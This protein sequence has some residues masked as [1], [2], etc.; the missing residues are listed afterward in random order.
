MK[1]IGHLEAVKN[2]IFIW[3]RSSQHYAKQKQH[4][5]IMF[6]LVVLAAVSATL[7]PYLMYYWEEYVIKPI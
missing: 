3:R 2:Y 1:L 7:F 4:F 6:L 5:M